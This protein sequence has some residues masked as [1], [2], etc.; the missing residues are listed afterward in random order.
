MPSVQAGDVR[1]HYEER[2][3]GPNLLLLVH[4]Y[5]ACWRW[6]EPVMARLDQARYHVYAPD[7]RGAGES[8]KPPSGYN[9]E[10]YTDD[11]FQF[12]Q[13]LRLRNLVYVGHSM[14]GI[15]GIQMALSHRELLRGLVLV[16]P[17]PA[18]PMELSPQQRQAL[19][20]VTRQLTTNRDVAL[21]WYQ[22][23]F[24]RP[25]AQR[26][27]KT[28]LEAGMSASAAH[29]RDSMRSILSTTLGERLG[30]I[31]TPSLLIGGDR[32]AIVPLETMLAT[33]RRISGCGLHVFH[34]VGHSPQLEVPEA[35][36]GVLT[37]FVENTL[38]ASA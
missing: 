3:R 36:V 35:F 4:G 28:I 15:I 16:D 33:Q 12:C 26:L 31:S 10:Q 13:A 24:Q 5:T 37:D 34:R 9:I 25:P 11:I 22:L 32:D 18:D 19:D 20:V 6:W 23:C 8:D 2:G 7:L 29:A 1:L 30:W 14:G 17:S 27:L 38:P 21:A